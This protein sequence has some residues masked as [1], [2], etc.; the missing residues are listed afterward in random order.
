MEEIINKENP[1]KGTPV[2]VFSEKVMF[3]QPYPL[4]AEKATGSVAIQTGTYNVISYYQDGSIEIRKFPVINPLYAVCEYWLDEDP[5]TTCL[6]QVSSSDISHWIRFAVINKTIPYEDLFFLIS[7]ISNPP[8]LS[9]RPEYE[10][11]HLIENLQSYGYRIRM[12]KPLGTEFVFNIGLYHAYSDGCHIFYNESI[13]YGLYIGELYFYSKSTSI[14]EVF[15]DLARQALFYDKLFKESGS[16]VL[17]SYHFRV[18][19]S[20]KIDPFQEWEYMPYFT[21]YL[22]R[23]RNHID[24]LSDDRAQCSRTTGYRTGIS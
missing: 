24:T 23:R 10:A 11:E 16:E 13:D 12:P 8:E 21:K 7:Y 5:D 1:V 9:E 2:K 19:D 4:I 20:S 18:Y 15:Y 14:E 17:P 22:Q 3:Q 6:G